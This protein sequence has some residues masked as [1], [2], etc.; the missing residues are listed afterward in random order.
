VTCLSILNAPYSTQSPYPTPA[1]T[2]TI[3]HV[4]TT[5]SMSRTEIKLREEI[6]RLS[7]ANVE[8]SQLVSMLEALTKYG[9]QGDEPVANSDQAKPF[10]ANALRHTT[11]RIGLFTLR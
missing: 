8:L 7:T 4:P 5:S 10:P 9:E 3:T 6:N 2:Y 1:V 11:Q